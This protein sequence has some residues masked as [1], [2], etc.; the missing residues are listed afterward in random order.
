[1]ALTPVLMET[2]S[3]KGKSETQKFLTNVLKY[4]M[5]GILP[6]TIGF[7][8]VSQNLIPV[9]ASSKYISSYKVVPIILPGIV[10]F[11]LSYLFNA[12]LIIE[13]KTS[14]IIKYAMIAS[15]IN[16][17]LN[18]LLIPRIGITGAAYATLFSY[19]FFFTLIVRGSFTYLPFKI[20]YLFI[21]KYLIYSGIMYF[22]VNS[23]HLYRYKI[24]TCLLQVVVGIFVYCALI[25]TFEVE[26]RSSLF[27]KIKAKCFG[28]QGSYCL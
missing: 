8:A 10:F 19:F 11:T 15:L 27:K 9:L 21:I 4:Y 14:K 12:G 25:L 5:L 20:P 16:L 23:I 17:S 26:I 7:I 18:Y 2:W 22:I 24:L 3:K 13:K 1:M 28:N 6:V